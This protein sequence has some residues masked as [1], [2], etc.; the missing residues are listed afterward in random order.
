MPPPLH[1][2]LTV[3]VEFTTAPNGLNAPNATA[4]ADTVQEAA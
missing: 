4:V 3:P 1:V 2:T